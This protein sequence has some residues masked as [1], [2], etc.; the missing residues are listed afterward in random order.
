VCSFDR[1]L[2]RAQ[3][4]RTGSEEGHALPVLIVISG[5]MQFGFGKTIS[6]APPDGNFVVYYLRYE[7]PPPSSQRSNFALPHVQG[8]DPSERL[9]QTVDGIGKALKDLKPRVFTVHS[10]E[11]VRKAIAVIVGEMSQM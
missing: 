7:F 9:E 1:K 4:E 5:M 6:L 11:G 8:P 10:A 2:C 3:K